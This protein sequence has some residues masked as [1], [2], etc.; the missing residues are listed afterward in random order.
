MTDSQVKAAEVAPRRAL[1]LHDPPLVVDL[2][3]LTLNPGVFVVRA[4]SS[5]AEAETILADWRPHMAVVDRDHDDSSP[6]RMIGLL[7]AYGDE[8]PL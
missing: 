5:L 4:A 2:V 3:T 8:D 1:V 6:L 7:V